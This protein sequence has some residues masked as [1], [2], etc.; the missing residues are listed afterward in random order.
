M[1]KL[2]IIVTTVL[3]VLLSACKE[4]NNGC[5]IN[6]TKFR[7]KDLPFIHID[8]LAVD[9]NYYFHGA[10]WL[11]K[12]AFY[13]SGLLTLEN[14][15][16]Y[17][18]LNS[19]AI[20]KIKYFDFSKQTGE[21]YDIQFNLTDSIFNL[22]VRVDTIINLEN[23]TASIFRI[24]NGWHNQEITTDLI[25]LVSKEKGILGSY[26]SGFDADGEWIAATRGNILKDYIDYSKKQFGVIE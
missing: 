6:Y 12:K 20:N 10:F 5:L 11:S 24:K 19:Y 7:E 16:F 26:I 3:M 23:A 13:S 8:S 9:C 21:L 4:E 25:Y 15:A 22:N 18:T 1:I 14:N 17:L 2:K